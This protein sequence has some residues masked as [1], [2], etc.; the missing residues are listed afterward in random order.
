MKEITIIEVGPQ[1][2]LPFQ[3]LATYVNISTYEL[4]EKA[5]PDELV[6]GRVIATVVA[7]L[8]S[9]NYAGL[10]WGYLDGPA[11]SVT[12]VV[13]GTEY[14]INKGYAIPIMFIVGPNP[15]VGT[16]ISLGFWFK[17]RDA[18]KYTFQ[19]LTAYG[20]PQ[21]GFNTDATSNKTIEILAAA[22]PTG[23]A[24]GWSKT[25][26]DFMNSML[27]LMMSMMMLMMMMSLMTSMMREFAAK[28][29]D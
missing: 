14:T 3:K 6:V 20:T 21:A 7:P 2:V 23:G 22:A 29:G 12:V 1:N 26:E 24:E 19:A 28:K 9:G 17:L 18:G 16:T 27:P 10:T 11:S 5:N 25:L 8:P 4:P 13:N 15:S